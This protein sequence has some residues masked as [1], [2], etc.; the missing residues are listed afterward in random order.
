M[1]ELTCTYLAWETP[2]EIRLPEELYAALLGP[3]KVATLVRYHGTG[4]APQWREP[5]HYADSWEG[6][7]SWFDRYLRKRED[8]G[9]TVRDH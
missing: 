6:M 9:K 1:Q 3:G 5:E 4:H 2:P 8:E 7:V